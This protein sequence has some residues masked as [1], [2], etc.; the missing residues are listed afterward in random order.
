MQRRELGARDRCRA[1]RR[2]SPGRAGRRPAPPL[3]GPRGRA[4]ASAGAHKFSR[5]GSLSQQGV[6]SSAIAR[7]FSPLATRAS[8]LSVLRLQPQLVEPSGLR[9]QSRG[10]RSRSASAG[11]RHKASASSSVV[12]DGAGSTSSVAFAVAHQG[13]EVRGVEFSWARPGAGSRGASDA[14]GRLRSRVRRF[15]T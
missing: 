6:S 11:P 13:V 9:N 2:G 4:R 12:T 5:S 15:E 10:A 1:G 14:L 7:A 8:S 3:G